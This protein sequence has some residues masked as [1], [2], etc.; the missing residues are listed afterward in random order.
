VDSVAAV[1]TRSDA[2]KDVSPAQTVDTPLI[3]P[4]QPA[5]VATASPAQSDAAA[6][7]STDSASNAAASA[8]NAVPDEPI[9]TAMLHQDT[10][11]PVAELPPPVSIEGPIPLP[12]SRAVALAKGQ[13]QPVAQR[14]NIAARVVR[15]RPVRRAIPAAAAPAQAP[16]GLFP[17]Q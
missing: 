15:P 11:E 1:E 4:E 8:S 9:K 5:A 16:T 6:T 2:A 12:R 7:P 3:A 13:P 10:P 17:F 14:R